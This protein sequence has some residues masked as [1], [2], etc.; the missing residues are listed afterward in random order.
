[1]NNLFTQPK[2][3]SRPYDICVITAANEHQARGYRAQLDWRRERNVL[4]E[5]TEFLV[6]AD[7]HG[8]RIGSGGSTIYVLYKLLQHL[9]S[10]AQHQ[11]SSIFEGKRILILHTHDE[12]FNR[13]L[14]MEQLMT[15]GGRWQDQIGGV[16]G[17]VKLIQTDPGLF[18]VPKT[19]WTDLT[20]PDLD[21]SD[22]FLMY[23][24][25]YRRM[26]K[27]IL[28]RIMGR[29][30]DRDRMTLELIERNQ[31]L[32]NEAKET[33]DLRDIDAFGEKI[34]E[35]WD[36]HKKLDP[37]ISNEKIE[38]IPERVSDYVCGARLLGAGSGGFLFMIAKGA[39]CRQEIKEIL[40]EAPPNNRARFF[41]SDI[42][43][44][45]LKVSVL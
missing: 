8:K 14:Y 24:T 19:S 35:V 39:E 11:D 23:Y 3:L 16:V 37:G 29:Y 13:T 44:N 9:A 31:R 21:I 6:I 43:H 25:G 15:T 2:E 41:D 38:K 36:L 30:L 17:V 40:A 12:L 33:L 18:Q 34:G 28:Q 20:P 26:A 1:M 27:N 32:A 10:S 5:E 4:P 45:G 7:P 22:R 42:D